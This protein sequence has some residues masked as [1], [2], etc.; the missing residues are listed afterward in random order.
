VADATKRVEFLGQGFPVP[1]EVVP[2]ALTLVRRELENLG[3]APELRQAVRKAGPV[4]T[5]HG[6]LILDTRFS[7]AFTPAEME[8]TLNN[9]PGVVEN[10][11]FTHPV[12]DLFVAARADCIEHL[13]RT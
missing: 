11:I 10:G 1:V 8:R 2:E 3:A 9:I 7:S 5:D 4:V 12:T 13:K 6:N